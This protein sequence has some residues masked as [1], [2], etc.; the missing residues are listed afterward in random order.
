MDLRSSPT[1]I[2]QQQDYVGEALVDSGV[3]YY[4]LGQYDEALRDLTS[5]LQTQRITV[6]T[7]HICVAHTLSN[8]GA[9]LLQLE[10]YSIAEECLQEALVIKE[11][12]R[13][14]QPSGF[15]TLSDTLNNLGNV[16]FM[17]GDYNRALSY[18]ERA[19]D[20]STITSNPT[21]SSTMIHSS[22]STPPNV[23]EI[24]DILYNM[25]QVYCFT[26]NYYD[27]LSKFSEAVELLV[28]VRGRDDSDIAAIIEKIGAI[29]LHLKRYEDAMEDFEEA[30]RVT[31]LS[32]GSY[33]EEVAPC[34]Y[35]IGLVHEAQ[36]LYR[37]AYQSYEDALDVYQNNGMDHPFVNR[38]RNKIQELKN[39]KLVLK[40]PTNSMVSR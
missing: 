25:G 4:G 14:E 24:A 31:R 30:L 21:T 12:Q 34:L 37:L 29:N 15:I 36:G 11:K 19:F 23:R 13:Q 6:G 1:T 2:L 38:I 35:H 40:I 8:I 33:H 20:E 28:Q 22:G 39:N 17:M 26:S 32:L 16:C 9:V 18:Y 5:A 10:R 3:R 7:E 27:A